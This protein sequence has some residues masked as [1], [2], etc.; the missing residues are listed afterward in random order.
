MSC[1]DSATHTPCAGEKAASKSL[2]SNAA[3]SDCNTGLHD[4]MAGPELN[5]HVEITKQLATLFGVT[6]TD[7]VCQPTQQSTPTL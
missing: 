5:K 7:Q 1:D 3:K 4:G 6:K 2:Q